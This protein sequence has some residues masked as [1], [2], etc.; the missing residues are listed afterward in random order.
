MNYCQDG[1]KVY[2]ATEIQ[3]QTTSAQIYG[4]YELQPNDVNG[5]PYFKMGLLGL[6][7]DGSGRWWIGPDS[8]KGQSFGFAYYNKDVFCPNQISVWDWW[9]FDGADWY[10]AYDLH[11]TCKCIFIQNETV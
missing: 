3:I 4:Q 8:V 11:I 5:R 9:L 1:L 7:W 6:W 2:F 10:L